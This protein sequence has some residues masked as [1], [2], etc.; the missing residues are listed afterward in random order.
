LTEDKVSANV[1]PPVPQENGL[2]TL[3]ESSTPQTIISESPEVTSIPKESNDAKL[4]D[5]RI[6]NRRKVPKYTS[7]SKG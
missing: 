5:K 7:D 1:E 2:Q 6:S 3:K 4:S